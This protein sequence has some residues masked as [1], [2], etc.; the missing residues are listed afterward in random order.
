MDSRRRVQLEVGLT[1]KKAPLDQE[2]VLN[3]KAVI[4]EMLVD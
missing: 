2:T 3:V 1:Y 4:Q